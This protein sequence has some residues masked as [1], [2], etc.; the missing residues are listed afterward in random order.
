MG[1]PLSLSSI[2]IRDR[3]S[4]I[5]QHLRTFDQKC[6]RDIPEQVTVALHGFQC[7]RPVDADCFLGRHG[8]FSFRGLWLFVSGSGGLSCSGLNEPRH[9]PGEQ[10]RSHRLRNV[11]VHTR[12]EALF[13]V[14]FQRVRGHGN[15]RDVAFGT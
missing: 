13:P 7:R 1:E 2:F 4:K 11:T 12:F 14:S 15:D 3:L 8:R 5:T 6:G 9:L 10:L